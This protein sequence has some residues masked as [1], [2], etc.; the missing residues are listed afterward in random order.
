MGVACNSPVEVMLLGVSEA[1]ESNLGGLDI[2]LLSG[3]DQNLR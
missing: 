2:H 3:H 1:L